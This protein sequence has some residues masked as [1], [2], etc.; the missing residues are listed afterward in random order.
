MELFGEPTA[1]ADGIAPLNK[2]VARDEVRFILLEAGS[3]IMPEIDPTLADYG[4]EVLRKRRGAD[5]RAG[6]SV[7]GIP[8]GLSFL[9]TGGFSR[10]LPGLNDFPEKDRP[11]VMMPFVSYHLMAG[12]YR[13]SRRIRSWASS[14]SGAAPC[15]RAPR[16]LA[17][18]YGIGGTPEITLAKFGLKLGI[19]KERVR[20]I[21]ARVNSEPR[22]FP[23]PEGLETLEI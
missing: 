9:V 10:P 20:Q 6:A 17:G 1:F 21:E 8:G 19:S 15:S 3:R 18:R 11:L 23:C 13:R 12:V 14:C 2:H 7:L 22:N 16:I 5:I 4:T